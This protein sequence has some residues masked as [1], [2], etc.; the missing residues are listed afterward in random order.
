[1]QR[2][3]VLVCVCVCVCSHVPHATCATHAYSCTRAH[4]F[5]V[6]GTQTMPTPCA[7]PPCM[8][9]KFHSSSHL[10]SRNPHFRTPDSE[11]ETCPNDQ[12]PGGVLKLNVS[13]TCVNY[14]SIRIPCN[15]VDTR[16]GHLKQLLGQYWLWSV[17]PHSGKSFVEHNNRFAL[18]P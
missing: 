17:D 12:A 3:F 7:L 15:M 16:S 1:M 5:S 13:G 2:P 9:I 8:W 11:S 4:V 6:L 10:V 18:H 14:T